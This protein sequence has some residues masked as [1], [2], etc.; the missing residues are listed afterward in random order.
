MHDRE[1]NIDGNAD[2]LR[3][4]FNDLRYLAVSTRRTRRIYEQAMRL[5]LFDQHAGYV[6]FYL[7]SSWI[8]QWE[9]RLIV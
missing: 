8:Q 5:Y 2:I 4:C 1:R 9:M 3:C 7:Y 6:L